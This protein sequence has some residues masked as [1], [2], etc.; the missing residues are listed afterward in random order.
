MR[1]SLGEIFD[2][3]A[4]CRQSRQVDTRNMEFICLKPKWIKFAASVASGAVISSCCGANCKLLRT[5]FSV[6]SVPL[7]VYRLQFAIVQLF[8]FQFSIFRARFS[9]F[10]L[11]FLATPSAPLGCLRSF[12]WPGNRNLYVLR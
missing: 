5:P 3:F 1:L 11:R 7:T 8:R 2:S 4:T 10:N 12:V 6:F 9:V